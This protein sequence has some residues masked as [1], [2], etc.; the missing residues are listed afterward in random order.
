[1]RREIGR[2]GGR[3]EREKQRQ[4]TDKGRETETGSARD[5]EEN[6]ERGRNRDRQRQRDRRPYQGERPSGAH[7]V[8]CT[9]Q[10]TASARALATAKEL[11]KMFLFS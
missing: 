3:G 1:M 10:L 4:Q 11:G 2:A 8:G 5:R 7:Y 6:G 9:Y